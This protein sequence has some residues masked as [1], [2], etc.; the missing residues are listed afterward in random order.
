MPGARLETWT[1][2]SGTDVSLLTGSV[3]YQSGIPD[4]TAKIQS[5]LKTPIDRADNFGA[6]LTTYLTPLATGNYTFWVA[7]DDSSELWLST[8]EN[9]MNKVLIA[10]VTGWTSPDQFTK[11]SS[12]KSSLVSLTAG[13]TYYLEGLYKEGGGGKQFQY[14]TFCLNRDW[15]QLISFFSL[16]FPQAITCP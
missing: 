6:R 15:E 5:L 11:Y 7:S 14:H 12:Q 4:E 3:A 10:K 13:S 9:P 2:I 1:G 16:L 8:D